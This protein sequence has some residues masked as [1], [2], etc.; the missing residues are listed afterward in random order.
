MICTGEDDL[1]LWQTHNNNLCKSAELDTHLH[2]SIM[3]TTSRLF[4]APNRY[5]WHTSWWKHVQ[6]KLCKTRFVSSNWK[7]CHFDK[8]TAIN[9]SAEF[10]TVVFFHCFTFV[11]IRSTVFI[12]FHEH[13]F[14]SRLRLTLIRWASQYCKSFVIFMGLRTRPSQ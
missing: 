13:L 9:C 11:F 8:L 10:W 2:S 12:Q 6:S 14:F 1:R 3:F 4:T 5:H 7:S